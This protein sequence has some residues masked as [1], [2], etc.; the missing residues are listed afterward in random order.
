MGQIDIELGPQPLLNSEEKFI[1]MPSPDEAHTEQTRRLDG[2][3]DQLDE[4]TFRKL[5]EIVDITLL[6]DFEY[7][8]EE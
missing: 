6:C 8:D 2:L 4:F 5:K 7:W 3:K 1:R